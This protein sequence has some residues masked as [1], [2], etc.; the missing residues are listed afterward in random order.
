MSLP[1]ELLDAVDEV[2]KR[3]GEGPPAVR[4]DVTQRLCVALACWLHGS[5]TTERAIEVAK[6]AALGPAARGRAD[7][8][9]DR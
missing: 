4:P 8:R 5:V 9:R 3:Q 2:L 1:A 6:G 7:G